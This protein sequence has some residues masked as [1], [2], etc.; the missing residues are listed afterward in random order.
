[1]PAFNLG[2]PAMTIGPMPKMTDKTIGLMN[3][4]ALVDCV[5]AARQIGEMMLDPPQNLIQDNLDW[6]LPNLIEATSQRLIL[7]YQSFVLQIGDQTI[8]VDAAIGEDGHFPDRPDWHHAKSDWLNQLG[9]AG[10]TPEDIDIVFLTH[11]HM[12]HTGWLT[13]WTG[14]HWQPTFPNARHLVSES[15]LEYWTKNHGKFAYMADSVPDC[16]FPVWD[17]GLF[18]YVA[19]GDEIALGL[20]VVDLAGHS[21]GMIGLEYRENGR[22]LASFCADLMHHPL[23]MTAPELSTIFCYD[24]AV[25]ALIRMAKLAEYA[26]EDTVMFCG[27]FPGESAGTVDVDGTGFRFTPFL[28]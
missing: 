12:D 21:V 18:E 20:E 4:S 27:H 23:Q 14:Q 28:G 25:A 16:I 15:E 9:K 24:A 26:R 1:M 13:R 5:G 7:S 17:A 11:L 8:L 6:L 10:L 3:V 22:L 19:P 2:E